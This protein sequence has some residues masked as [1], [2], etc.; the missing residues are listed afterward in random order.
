MSAVPELVVAVVSKAA[1]SRTKVVRLPLDVP[2][3]RLSLDVH[4]QHDHEG[5]G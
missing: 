3:V 4:V 2:N 1:Q 5:I